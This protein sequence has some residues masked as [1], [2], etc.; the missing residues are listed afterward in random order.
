MLGL[1]P[2]GWREVLVGTLILAVLATG[3]AWVWW[4]LVLLPLAVWVWLLSFFRD[5]HREIPSEPGILVSPA[6][7]T[8]SDITEIADDPRLGGPAVSVGIFLSVFNVHVNR[9]P[10]DGKVLSAQH[11]PGRF[12]NALK[13]REASEFN[14]AN[15]VVLGDPA[16]CRPLVVVRQIVGLIARRIVFSPAVGSTVRRGERIGMMKFGSRTEL[17]VPRSADPEILVRVGQKVR[18]GSDVVVRLGV[19]AATPKSPQLLG[20][21]G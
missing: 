21:P 11:T 1:T 9:S 6:D 18:G 20:T 2:Y 5:P 15:T 8:V 14:E 19:R 17:I 3:L 16:T 10:C 4:P 12:I 13:H 7:G